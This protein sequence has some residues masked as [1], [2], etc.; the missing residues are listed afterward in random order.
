MRLQVEI[1]GRCIGQLVLYIRFNGRLNRARDKSEPKCLFVLR[2]GR[3]KER[4]EE[5]ESRLQPPA[6]GKA[7]QQIYGQSHK[8][9]GERY[10]AQQIPAPHTG[11]EQHNVGWPQ[12]KTVERAR[13][14]R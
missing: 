1:R 2:T 4:A 5:P 8:L 3:Q 10:Q 7:R 13:H 6:P 11:P 12:A 14:P 9:P